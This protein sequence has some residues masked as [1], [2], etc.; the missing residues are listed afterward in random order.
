[1]EHPSVDRRTFLS[2]ES[3]AT[4]WPNLNGPF[5]GEY[6]RLVYL[7]IGTFK[8]GS[9]DLHALLE[10]LSDFKLRAKGVVRGREGSERERAVI[11][12]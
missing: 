3:T 9:K 4:I 12:T 8:K 5:R 6:G 11:L 2:Q 7:V 1:M 10:T